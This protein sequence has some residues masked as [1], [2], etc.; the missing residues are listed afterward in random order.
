MLGTAFA[1][2]LAFV[3]FLAFQS[4][5]RAQAAAGQEA[6]AVTDL[7]RSANLIGQPRPTDAP[8]RAAL[9]RTPRCR[10]RVARILQCLLIGGT[11]VLV[12]GSIR[13][14]AMQLSISQFERSSSQNAA[15]RSRRPA[16]FGL[17]LLDATEQNERAAFDPNGLARSVGRAQPF[18]QRA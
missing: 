14:T 13:P 4:Y 16:R 2:L 10:G 9:L 5:A 18:G 11:T 6:V 7:A 12:V 17:A 8:R 1:I 3:I 15:L